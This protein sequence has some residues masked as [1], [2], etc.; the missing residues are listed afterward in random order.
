MQTASG[1]LDFDWF[2]RAEPDGKQKRYARSARTAEILAM[3]EEH[4]TFDAAGRW[5]GSQWWVSLLGTPVEGLSWVAS[6]DAMAYAE[7]RLD[8]MALNGEMDEELDDE[9]DMDDDDGA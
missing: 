8:E 4:P 2:W 7:T 6:D 1:L 9:Y 5:M 3:C